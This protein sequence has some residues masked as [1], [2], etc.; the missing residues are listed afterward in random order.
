V[1]ASQS[2]RSRNQTSGGTTPRAADTSNLV[3]GNPRFGAFTS[4][5]SN[6]SIS[7]SENALGLAIEQPTQQQ[8]SAQIAAPTPRSSYRP[9]L[10]TFSEGV[11]HSN[12]SA[13]T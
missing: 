1:I 12:Q 2:H 9:F 13:S 7:S 8:S 6:N 5:P 11:L 4:A 3:V 10:R